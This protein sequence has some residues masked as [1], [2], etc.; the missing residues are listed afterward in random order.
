MAHRGVVLLLES[1]KNMRILKH[2][3][4]LLTEICR[5]TRWLKILAWRKKCGTTDFEGM[6]TENVWDMR[7]FS[8]DFPQITNGK[9]KSARFLIHAFRRNLCLLQQQN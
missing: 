7:H 5:K 8:R 6:V 2:R 3:I 4:F 1:E 9:E